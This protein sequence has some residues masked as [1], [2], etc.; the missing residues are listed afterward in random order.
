MTQQSETYEAKERE[1]ERK[2]KGRIK[3]KRQEEETPWDMEGDRKKDWECK[4]EGE[5]L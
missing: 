1:K 2:K 4:D 5:I 3:R